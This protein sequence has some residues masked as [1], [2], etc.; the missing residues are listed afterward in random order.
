VRQ[1]LRSENLVEYFDR[2]AARFA[3]RYGTDP[4]FYER[5]AVWHRAIERAL[6]GVP[7]GA[8]C[9]D[10][11]CGDGS[12]SRW[13]AAQGRPVVGLDQSE[14]MLD[15]A[16]RR[17]GE[18]GLGPR[19]VYHRASLPLD[20]AREAEYEGKA[21]LIVCSSVLEYVD[22]PPE[23]LAQCRRLLMPGGI[24][25]VS[26]PNRDSIYR[27]AQRALHGLFAWTDS[28]LRHQRHQYSLPV[29]GALLTRL[30]Y[31]VVDAVFFA[32]PS[33]RYVARIARDRRGRRLATMMLLAAH[34]PRLFNPDLTRS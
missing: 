31:Q 10:L 14:A 12:L 21:G 20:P 1:T 7:Q 15:L 3:A 5:R 16:R 29:A 17:A 33:H 4:A 24:L 28:Y 9:L 30:G 34:K 13:V 23:V 8:L 18:E 22:D 27:I 32:L 25:L 6:P 19:A 26:L 2:T 11:G